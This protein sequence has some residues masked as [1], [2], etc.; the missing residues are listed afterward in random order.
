MRHIEQHEA[1]IAGMSHLEPLRAEKLLVKKDSEEWHELLDVFELDLGVTPAL[2]CNV[3][4]YR[5]SITST[6]ANSI[7]VDRCECVL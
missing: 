6:S 2:P 7:C 4:D 5:A 3:D 1:F